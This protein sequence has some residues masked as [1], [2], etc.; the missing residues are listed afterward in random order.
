MTKPSKVIDELRKAARD[1]WP[2]TLR[3]F[4][5]AENAPKSVEHTATD[6]LA[7][8]LKLKKPDLKELL[9][10]ILRLGLAQFIVGRR[11]SASRLV[12]N[13]TPRSIAAVATG[14]ARELT[15]VVKNTLNSDAPRDAIA[16]AFQL[17]RDTKVT[18]SLP[19]D[20]TKEEAARFAAFV[21]TLPFE[22]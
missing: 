17:R 11:G 12:W 3:F 19:A 18:V 4:T 16:H 21:Q 6:D 8:A 5:W 15:P 22:K 20:L 1:G 7:K 13:F 9:Q 14:Q 2:P 10:G